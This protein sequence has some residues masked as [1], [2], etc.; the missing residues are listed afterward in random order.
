MRR[1]VVEHDLPDAVVF[2]GYMDRDLPTAYHAAD[3]CV[4]PE[5]GNDACCRA[6]LEAAAS[7]LPVYAAEHIAAARE[8]IT[9]EMGGLFHADERDSLA[10]CLV[11]LAQI[12][13]ET[14][15]MQGETARTETV[16]RMGKL[17]LSKELADFYRS[18]IHVEHLA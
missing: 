7:G 5:V 11:R 2:T 8:F 1:W 15:R 9:D 13:S 10:R 3:A 16:R 14:L 18:F 12:P 6:I 4:Q 17:L